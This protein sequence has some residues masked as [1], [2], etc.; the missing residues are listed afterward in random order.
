VVSV[1]ADPLRALD[2]DLTV[3]PGVGAFTA[4]ADRIAS[5][6]AAIRDALIGGG[7]DGQ[8][9]P[10]LGIC[11]GMQILFEG[12][13][14]GPGVGLGVLRGQ[15]TRLRAAR[16]PHMGW[17][18]SHASGESVDHRNAERSAP[19][20][21]D[22]LLERS[23]LTYAY[24]AHAYVCRPVDARVIAASLTIDGDLVP[25]MVRWRRTVGVQF[26]PEKSGAEGLRFL[27]E[28]VTAAVGGPRSRTAQS[29]VI[30]SSA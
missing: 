2:S 12:S 5:D 19:A 3:L 26:H 30:G 16:V 10:A 8:G 14:E 13:T 18:A 7:R 27:R 24:Y 20:R 6:R 21:R 22:A 1:E 9:Q 15:V 25:T 17:N 11:L 4:A 29:A 23:G 28:V